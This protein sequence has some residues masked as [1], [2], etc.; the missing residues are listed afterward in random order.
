MYTIILILHL[1]VCFVLIAVILL[2]AGR[3]GGLADMF[4]G[5]AASIL[6][7]RAST[8]LTKATTVCAVIFILTSLSL[9]I[10]SAKQ[11]QSLMERQLRVPIRPPATALPATKTESQTPAASTSSEPAKNASAPEE[12]PAAPSSTPGS[13]S[14][15]PENP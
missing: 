5:G 1:L 9:A 11:G 2:Q 4:G 14:S 8:Y 12:P 10:L 3:G 13:E 6:G 7:T 15:A